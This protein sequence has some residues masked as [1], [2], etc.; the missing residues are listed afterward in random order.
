MPEWLS[1]RGKK[2]KKKKLSSPRSATVL[3]TITLPSPPSQNTLLLLK[4]K[5]KTFE[6]F[7]QGEVLLKWKGEL[8]RGMADEHYVFTNGVAGISAAMATNHMTRCIRL[9]QTGC[10]QAWCECA[11]LRLP[12]SCPC[13]AAQSFLVTPNQSDT[14]ARTHTRWQVHFGTWSN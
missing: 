4:K 10:S 9:P 3:S 1:F 5:K 14:H 8:G 6:T 12:K 7:L 11:T 13:L 2:Q